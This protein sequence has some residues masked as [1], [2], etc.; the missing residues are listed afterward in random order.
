MKT[1]PVI[2]KGWSY[3]A[4]SFLV[5]S[6]CFNSIEF[7]ISSKE[8]HVKSRE[9]SYV[10]FTLHTLMISYCIFGKTN[11]IAEA[12]GKFLLSGKNTGQEE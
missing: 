11:P 8:F 2:D 4:A 1:Q 10:S 6:M 9:F 12:L 5:L 7:D 3:L